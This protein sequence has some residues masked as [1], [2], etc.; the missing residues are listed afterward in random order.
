MTQE[1]F[2]KRYTYSP[3]RDRIGGGGFGTVYKAY[4]NLLHREVAIK[5]S[6]VKTTADGKKTFSLKDEFEALNHVPKHPNIANY[7]ELYS[8]EDHRGLCDYAV[9]Q[10]YPDGNL[11]NA[12]KQGLTAE[13][14]EDIA[15]QLLEGI[16]FLHKHKVVH[17]DLKP[18]N[19]LIVKHGGRII[20]LIT[21]FGLSKAAG[22]VDGSVFSNSFGA[23]TPRYSSPE[24]LQGL[25]LR[26][27][28]DLWSFGA[29]LYEVFTGQQLFSPGSGAS[30][31][32][33]ADMEIY[34]KIV[35]G[36]VSGLSKMPEKWRKVAERCLVVDATKRAKDAGE[37]F[38]VIYH[39][40]EDSI[41]TE[42]SPNGSEFAT[43]TSSRTVPDKDMLDRILLKIVLGKTDW[44]TEEFQYR[45]DHWQ[46]I[47]RGLICIQKEE[48]RIKVLPYSYN[49]LQKVAETKKTGIAKPRFLS[50][51]EAV[52]LALLPPNDLD[53][54][55]CIIVVEKD[56]FIDMAFVVYGDG[57]YETRYTAYTSSFNKER[58]YSF[59]IEVK[60]SE[61]SVDRIILAAENVVD[62]QH[63]KHIENICGVSVEYRNDL[64]QLVK[65]GVSVYAG[66]LWGG[67]KNVLLLSAVSQ[68][69]GVE[70]DDGLMMPLVYAD[71]YIPT[72][73]SDDLLLDADKTWF[74]VDLW[75]GNDKI[76]RN[77]ANIATLRLK[78]R[79]IEQGKKREIM[80]TVDIGGL[81][82]FVLEDKEYNERVEYRWTN[83]DATET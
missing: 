76:A 68:N 51:P 67:V 75:E 39:N 13:Q 63:K 80:V 79:C 69:I 74:V 43:S 31:T 22:V 49:Y 60:R 62:F 77:N 9:M 6:E 10:Y 47:E 17:R 33:Q 81:Y 20:P 73:R 56:G 25:P 53:E 46:D 34:N 23:G 14:K 2:F 35:N 8:Y 5:V 71:D 54:K 45:N 50:Y 36:N 83:D 12:I 38:S 18:G 19:I 26:F 59:L 58:V 64:Q 82:S 40:D 70:K 24:Q 27:N 3:S 66:V 78:N 16:D 48:K 57:V 15:T 30:N 32:A 65:Q 21:D 1:E 42:G 11:S 7:E 44:T 55:N 28:T 61:V 52:A 37:L 72:R 41:K 29:I 4:D